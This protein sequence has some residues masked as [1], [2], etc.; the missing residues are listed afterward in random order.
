MK[1][2]PRVCCHGQ[3]AVAMVLVLFLSLMCTVSGQLLRKVAVPHNAKPGFVVTTLPYWGQQYTM[4]VATDTQM[5]MT[6]YFV[7]SHKGEITVSSDVSSLLGH[8]FQLQV[9]DTLAT[10]SW[11][12]IIEIEVKN[13][14]HMLTFLQPSYTGAVRENAELGTVV[15]GLENLILQDMIRMP[16]A[17]FSI[18]S[19]PAE[20]FEL[21]QPA[22]QTCVLEILTKVPLDREV[23]P[24]Y[25]LTI[26]ADTGQPLDDM[27]MTEVEIT[28]LDENDNVPE[29]PQ[30][31]YTATIQDSTPSQTVVLEVQA[32]DPDVGP[33]QYSM[34]P[35]DVFQIDKDTGSIR[36]KSHSKL[37]HKTYAFQVFVEDQDGQRGQPAVAQIEVETTLFYETS[38][39]SHN[40]IRHSRWRRDIGGRRGKPLKE[41]EVMEN[42]YG[43]LLQLP[44]NG[45]ERFSFKDPV[46]TNLDIDRV[47][48]SIS[49]KPGNSLDFEREPEIEFVVLI[50]EQREN[51]NCEYAILLYVL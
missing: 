18:Q 28:V 43:E 39:K 11:Q 47:T 23:N 1:S 31:L 6:Q 9:S 5:D 24:R 13:G 37:Q 8:T 46:P 2:F 40:H 26:R 21:R 44:S 19:G 20:L 4:D 32:N 12:D 48:G 33:L 38:H 34:H 16:M 35:H 50:V 29:F 27:A 15:S 22:D 45:Q 3:P 17:H 25:V 7:V 42:M 36:I 30:N 14:N 51:Q 10:E 49:L 41:V